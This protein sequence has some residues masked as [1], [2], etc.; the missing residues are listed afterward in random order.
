[1]PCYVLCASIRAVSSQVEPYCEGAAYLWS[2]S[3]DLPENQFCAT[4]GRSLYRA[5]LQTDAGRKLK[6]PKLPRSRSYP[7]LPYLGRTGFMEYLLARECGVFLGCPRKDRT[8][9]GQEY[10]LAK[11]ILSICGS[12]KTVQTFDGKPGHEWTIKGLS[13][14]Q[15]QSSRTKYNSHT[16]SGGTTTFV[17]NL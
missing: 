6:F 2:C 4:Q 9:T 3:T 7:I 5:V 13:H 17:L 10:M 15:K 12:R 14:P 8:H 16:Q 1:M 11:G